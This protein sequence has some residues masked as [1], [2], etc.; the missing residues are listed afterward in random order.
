MLNDVISYLKMANGGIQFKAS[1][2]NPRTESKWINVR[3]SVLPLKKNL[4]LPY[5]ASWC[6]DTHIMYKGRKVQ[7][8]P[9]P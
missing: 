7:L 6:D 3:G 5:G 8:V 2:Y 1:D 9:F 4:H